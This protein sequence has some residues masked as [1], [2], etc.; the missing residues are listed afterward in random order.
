MI[1]GL[2]FHHLG[3]A[4][5]TPD[6]AR[7]M[8]MAMGYE[9]EAHVFDPLQNVNLGMCYHPSMPAI[10][11]IFPGEGVGPID[12]M[13]GKHADGLVYHVCYEC[14]DLNHVVTELSASVGGKL[15]CISPPKPAVLFGGKNVSFYMG[16]GLGLIEIISP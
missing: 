15:S 8:L 6:P 14:D 4:V 10:E 13:L 5:K 12:R 1:R 16:N 7:S 3:L 9:C 2:T 11:I